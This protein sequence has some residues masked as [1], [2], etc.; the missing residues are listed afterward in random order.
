MGCHAGPVAKTATEFKQR[1]QGRANGYIFI[2]PEGIT[3]GQSG[4]R[5]WADL[6][7][8]A[9][10]GWALVFMAFPRIRSPY[11]AAAYGTTPTPSD[12]DMNKLADTDIHRIL[13]GGAKQTRTQWF[14][15]SEQGGGV[16]ADGSLTNSSTQYNE[17]DNPSAWSSDGTSVGQTFRR[18]RGTESSWSATITAASGGCSE[19][20]AGWSN[21]YEQSCVQSWR[22]GCEGTPCL[23]HACATGVDRAE[24]LIIWAT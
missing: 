19:A 1:N 15:T 10:Y 4:I 17:F 23:N 11:V 24:K 5:V 12:T 7:S 9:N 13:N 18:K 8:D 14:H 22:C 6:T 2:R 21:Y 16:F 3:S 20:A